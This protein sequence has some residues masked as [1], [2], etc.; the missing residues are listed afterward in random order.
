M[1]SSN[2][3]KPEK[4]LEKKLEKLEFIKKNNISKCMKWFSK[5]NLSYNDIF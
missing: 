2:D 4:K 3:E 1:N 5:N